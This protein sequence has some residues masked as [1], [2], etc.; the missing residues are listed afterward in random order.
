MILYLESFSTPEKPRDNELN[1]S[2]MLYDSV[3]AIYNV[4][5]VSQHGFLVYCPFVRHI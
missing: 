5:I 2:S 4:D 1:F 3:N